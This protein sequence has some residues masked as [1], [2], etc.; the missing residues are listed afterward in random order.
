MNILTIRKY[1]TDFNEPL[2]LYV[3]YF[4]STS[5]HREIQ[6]FQ[7][8]VLDDLIQFMTSIFIFSV[9]YTFAT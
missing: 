7:I 2:T 1:V 8:K 6:N 3:T 9:N 5:R 4:N